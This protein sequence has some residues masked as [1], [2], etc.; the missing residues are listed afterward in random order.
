[1]H[2]YK[3][4]IFIIFVAIFFSLVPA[5]VFADNSLGGDNG[6]CPFIMPLE[7]QVLVLFRQK[8]YDMEKDST[9]KHT[10]IDIEGKE[11][12]AVYASGNGV[13]SYCGISPVGGRTVV[14]E[15]NE[16][17]RTTYLNLKNVFVQPGTYVKQ[18]QKIATL[19]V[20][21][22]PSS[23]TVHLHFGVIYQGTYLDPLD[24]LAIDYTDITAFIALKNITPDFACR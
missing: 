16:K 8:Y 19:G 17:I 4:I 3:Y 21:D 11:N 18:G 7:G 12:A 15:H 2:K 6:K 24:V 10:G 13:V 14:I 22:D 9:R 5:C 23:D 20:F 1:M